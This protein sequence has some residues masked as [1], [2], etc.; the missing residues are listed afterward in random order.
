MC[1]I[2]AWR[3]GGMQACMRKRYGTEAC[4]RVYARVGMEA[5]RYEGGGV[6][7]WRYGCMEVWTYGDVRAC[8]SKRY[9]GT[10]IYR[11]VGVYVWRRASV[12]HGAMK[13]GIAGRR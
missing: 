8:M 4:R 11:H 10:E 12:W 5:W 1:R 9:G 6:D 3:Y 13:A 2:E 7:V